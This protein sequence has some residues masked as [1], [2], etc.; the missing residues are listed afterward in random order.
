MGRIKDWYQQAISKSNKLMK[1]QEQMRGMLGIGVE[2]RKGQTYPFAPP[3]TEN[4]NPYNTELIEGLTNT[5]TP[6]SVKPLHSS[7]VSSISAVAESSDKDG[8]YDVQVLDN[9]GQLK[10]Y[11]HVTK[12]DKERVMRAEAACKTSG[13]NK[14]GIWWQGKEPSYGAAVNQILKPKYDST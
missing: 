12:E 14:F 13:R 2:T 4:Y 10:T 11:I 7:V 3:A 5:L 9:Y 6:E 8:L 1:G